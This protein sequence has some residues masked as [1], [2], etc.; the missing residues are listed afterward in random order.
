VKL[1]RILAA[2]FLLSLVLAS[3]GVAGQ[4]PV[5]VTA[6]EWGT[7]T[8]ITAPDGTTMEW[9]PL[10][11]SSELPS[12]VEHLQNANFKG[13]LRGTIR[14]ETPV[15]YFYSPQ[16]TTL[17]VH[18]TF[19]QGLITEWY[20]HAEVPAI[21][22]NQ[23]FDVAQKKKDG[24]I[25]WP[26]VKIDPATSAEFP[27]EA[28]G[29]AYYAARETSS[30]PLAVPAS[31]GA[32]REKFLFYRGVSTTRPPVTA[33][34]MS[35]STVLLQNHLAMPIANVILF[36]RRGNNIGF[37]ILG[38]VADEAALSSPALDGSLEWLFSELEGILIAQGLFPDEA[39]AML[40]TWNLSWFEE[41]S[42]IL[43]IVPRSF[44]DSVLPLT[45][46]PAPAQLTRVFVGRLE[47]ITPATQQ[48]VVSAFAANDRSTLAKYHRFLEP[49]LR[50]L[51]EAA[52]DRPTRDRLTAYLDSVYRNFSFPSRE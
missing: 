25:F 15:L 7:F 11:A 10:A 8:S 9:L 18:V 12:F 27:V 2:V 21:S 13:G 28:F 22:P 20:P 17:S 38:P 44:V 49:I 45:I 41:G 39:H 47:L 46:N 1:S 14:M 37:R 50:T 32:Q 51:L 16:E 3:P 31:A 19:S 33:S 52:H 42:R 24:T 48:A 6:H 34:I 4:S 5:A 29:D 23:L 26:S 36:E 43:Y 40:E 30:A 35:N